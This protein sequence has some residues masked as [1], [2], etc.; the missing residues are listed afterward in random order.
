MYTYLFNFIFTV[1]NDQKNISNKKKKNHD[2][3][4]KKNIRYRYAY[5][6]KGNRSS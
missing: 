2:N 4:E 1:L 3:E 6:K 5:E